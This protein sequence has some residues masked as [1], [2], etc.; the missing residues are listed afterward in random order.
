MKKVIVGM[1]G[2]VDS[3]VTAYLLKAY[4]YDVIGV[5]LKMW[6]SSMDELS[7][8]CEIDVAKEIADKLEI[9]Y[10]VRN[11]NEAFA[12]YV[13]KPFIND[14]L[15]G[16]TPNPCVEC[17]HYVKWA[18][19]MEAAAAFNADYVATG[20]YANIIKLDNGRYTVK[21]ADSKMKDQTYM[22]YKLTQEQLAHTLMPLGNLSKDEV[23][24]IARKVG[25]SVANKPD[26]MEI[27][28][29]TDGKYS[30][31]IEEYSEKEIP[32]EGNFVDEEG[33]VLGRHKG[34]IHYTIGQRKG[35]GI[36]FGHPMFVKEIRA[37]SNE[38]VLSEEDALFTKEVF[39]KDLNFMSIEGI[40]EGE[41]IP[42]RVKIRYRHEGEKAILTMHDEDTV[43]ISFE[44][45]V[46][47]ATSGQS[48]VFYDADDCVIGGGR[49]I[50]Q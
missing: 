5:T 19:M 13:T 50:L 35:L 47:A 14:Y 9:P 10:Y 28:F 36:A 18:G 34:I 49:I 33:N 31:Y 8:C 17:N 26:S 30:D 3:A 38:V 45:A 20:H 44:K 2:G 48:A 1:S 29:V 40:R 42:A 6:I 22:I 12:K 23:R 25:I 41:E 4:G 7:R 11:I 21:Q 27:C 16:R 37:E 43:K 39:V 46:R 32:G 15:G 24:E